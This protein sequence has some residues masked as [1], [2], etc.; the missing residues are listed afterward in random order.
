MPIK[1]ASKN[2]EELRPLYEGV[3]AYLAKERTMEE[4]YEKDGLNEQGWRSG[5]TFY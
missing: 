3:L 1:I 4:A 2:Q 5:E